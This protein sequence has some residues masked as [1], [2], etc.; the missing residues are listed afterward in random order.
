MLDLKCELILT[1][2]SK[3]IQQHYS[4]NTKHEGIK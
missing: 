1:K 2:A 3:G 4:K